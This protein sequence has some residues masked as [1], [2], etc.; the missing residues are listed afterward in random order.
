MNICIIGDGLSSLTLAKNLINKKINVSLYYKNIKRKKSPSRTIGVSN[1]NLNF[2]NSNILQLKKNMAWGVKE[3][4]IFSDKKID[5]KI[6]NFKKD[7]KYLFHIFKN[8]VVQKYLEESL[9]KS[10]L[11]QKIKIEK[12]LFYSNILKEKK[13]DLIINCES[14]NKIS[15]NLFSLKIDKNYNSTSYI[16]ILKHKKTENTKAVQI[17]TKNGPIAFLPISKNETSVVFSINNNCEKIKESEIKYLI[18]KYN[19]KYKIESFT[20]I[21]KYNLKFLHSRKYYHK[22]IIAFGEV[23]HKVHPLAGQGFNIVLRDIKTLSQII[24]EKIELGLPIDTSVCKKFEKST[25]HINLTFS[26]G[27][28]FIHGIFRFDAQLKKNYLSS[29]LK[30]LSYIFQFL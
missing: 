18:N 9:K 30:I 27:I 19:K 26:S 21:E 23:I 6:M 20:K 1:N 14:K 29:L 13:Y 12:N 17:F 25:R 7:K 2:F 10:K 5:E 24:Q 22:N 15:K 8:H 4:E 11:F 3:I 16:T 28:D